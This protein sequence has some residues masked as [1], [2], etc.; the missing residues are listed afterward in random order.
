MSETRETNPRPRNVVRVRQ[1]LADLVS[2]FLRR[3]HDELGLLPAAL[4]AGDFKSLRVW[5]HNLKGTG[6]AYGFQT[7]TDIGRVL[8]DAAKTEDAARIQASANQLADFLLDLEVVY[9]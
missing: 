3:R 8:E 1:D 7:I 9:V 5:G 4:Q 6:A 2:I